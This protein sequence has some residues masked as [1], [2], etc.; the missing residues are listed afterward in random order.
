MPQKPL[1]RHDLQHPRVA[2]IP[3]SVLPSWPPKPWFRPI[4]VGHA[5]CSRHSVEIL[6]SL[7]MLLVLLLAVLRLIRP[8]HSYSTDNANSS[9]PLRGGPQ[10]AYAGNYGLPSINASSPLPEPLQFNA[11]QIAALGQ[12]RIDGI[13]A[14]S[15]F[16]GNC[17]K[18][19]NSIATLR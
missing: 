7:R 17:S 13:I 14:S 10:L 18:V 9:L 2:A 4:K 1:A 12:Q 19:L 6:T 16:E 11:T 8:A 3:P 15:A 5:S